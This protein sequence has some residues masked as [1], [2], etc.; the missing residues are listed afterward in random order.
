[1][2]KEKNENVSGSIEMQSEELNLTTA[3]VK[4]TIRAHL[5]SVRRQGGANQ[6]RIN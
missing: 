1:M 5:E 4:K 6:F 2:S 3:K